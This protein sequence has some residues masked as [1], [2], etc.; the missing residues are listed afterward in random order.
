MRLLARK[1]K[2]ADVL[3]GAATEDGLEGFADWD[4]QSENR[5]LQ[6]VARCLAFAFVVQCLALAAMALAVYGLLPLKTVEPMLLIQKPRADQIV[7][8]HPFR[9]GTHGFRLLT[10][11][12]VRDFVE[13]AHT[14]VPDMAT[15][16]ELWGRKLYRLSSPAV[17]GLLRDTFEEPAQE[18]IDEGRSRGVEIHGD[19][20]LLE[21]V[22]GV[23]YW[24]V[25]FDTVDTVLTEEIDRQRWIASL[26]VEFQPLEVAFE[27]RYVN[28]LGFQVVGYTVARAA[29]AGE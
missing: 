2:P 19:P 28:P 25:S 17:F 24:Q 21:E 6:W 20:R 14:I 27:D 16:Q 22:Q 15:M 13:T 18:L 10:E 9:Q 26:V 3:G 4:T 29:G 5:R 11:F 7:E 8:V 23:L 12:L 1:K